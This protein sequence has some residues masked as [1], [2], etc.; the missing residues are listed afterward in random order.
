MRRPIAFEEKL[1]KNFKSF[2]TVL[3]LEATNC[4]KSVVVTATLGGLHF[5]TICAEK[6]ADGNILDH[7]MLEEFKNAD[8]E[9]EFEELFH[10]RTFD[11][12]A[13]LSDEREALFQKVS[14]AKSSCMTTK[15]LD[16]LKGLLHELG[17]IINFKLDAVSAPLVVPKYPP[18]IYCLT[19]D[20]RPVNN[21][22]LQT[23]WPMP[24]IEAE[25]AHARGARAYA[26]IDLC[27]FYWQAQ[28]HPDIQ[29]L[30]L[31]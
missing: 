4:Q 27:G 12:A 26:A 5:A 11:M 19:L 18:D 8:I 13:N 16:E 9:Q 21:A 17:D 7:R 3:I 25:Q 30:L 24:N 28:L 1:E 10:P 20:Y 14:E 23:F 6:C 15:G 22:T 29:P 31:S 2:I